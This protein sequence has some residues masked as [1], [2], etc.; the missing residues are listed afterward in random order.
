MRADEGGLDVGYIGRRLR[1]GR[2][3]D[4]VQQFARSGEIVP[5]SSI[6]E[7]PIVADVGESRRAGR[8]TGS[9]A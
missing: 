1:F 4:D 9:D 6:G 5:A 2:G 3:G 8:A 7:Q